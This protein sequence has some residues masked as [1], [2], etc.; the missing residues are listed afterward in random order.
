[1]PLLVSRDRIYF[2][3]MKEV[4]PAFRMTTR[5]KRIVNITRQLMAQ[6]IY[7]V[8]DSGCDIAA[9]KRTIK[10]FFN[11]ADT[12]TAIIQIA[13][14]M[15]CKRTFRITSGLRKA[16]NIVRFNGYIQIGK[17]RCSCF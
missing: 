6:C 2:T 12:R 5:K 8:S 3:G 13:Q 7:C 17:E 1:M 16:Q 4:G 9:G 11:T 15:C 14:H 10:C